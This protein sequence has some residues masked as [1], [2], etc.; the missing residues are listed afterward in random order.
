[1]SGGTDQALEGTIIDDGVLKYTACEQQRFVNLTHAM[2]FLK[3]DAHLAE[4]CARKAHHLMRQHLKE[5]FWAL[6]DTRDVHCDIEYPGS[7]E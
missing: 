7:S 4:I 3:S 1:M 2:V 6:V 5:C